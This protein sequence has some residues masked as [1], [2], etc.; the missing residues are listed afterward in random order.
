MVENGYG[1]AERFV[2]TGGVVSSVSLRDLP[3]PQLV[4]FSIVPEFSL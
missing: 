2:R 3:A 4:D 1:R